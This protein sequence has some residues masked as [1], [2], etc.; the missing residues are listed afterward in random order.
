VSTGGLLATSPSGAPGHPIRVLVVD[1]SPTV[2]QLL[3]ELLRSDPAFAVVGEASDGVAAVAQAV[4]LAP[5]LITMDVHMPVLDG[6][7]ATRTIMREAP[8]SILVVSSTASPGDVQ[9]ALDAT[10]AGALMVVAKPTTPSDPTFPAQREQFLAMARAMAGV[11]VVRRW[12][13]GGA[14]RLRTT[15]AHP[16]LGTLPL[17]AAPTASRPRWGSGG[18]VPGAARVIAIGTSTGGPAALRRVLGD[19]PPTLSVPVLVVQHMANGFIDG[20]ASWLDGNT[21][22]PVRVAD[23]GAPLVAGTVLVAPDDRHLAV[24]AEGRVWLQDGPPVGGFRPS[25]DVLF[26]ACARVYGAGVVALVLTGMGRDGVDGVARVHAAGG[27]VLAQDEPSS[28]IYGMAREAV[29]AGVVHEVLP[30]DALGRR[31]VELDAPDA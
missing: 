14:R 21:A 20:L 8:T 6:L 22:I 7:E 28:V 1:D 29:R 16:M 3:V 18:R 10:Q 9:L 26:E 5:D 17:P 19:L 31:I 24:S 23:D 13:P 25:A 2:R 27:R 12:E 4:A 11:K 15:P 30:L